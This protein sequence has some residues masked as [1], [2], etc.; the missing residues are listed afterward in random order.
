MLTSAKANSRV[1]LQ[2]EPTNA[3]DK[4]AY[5]VL[6]WDSGKLNHV[7]YV[8]R[9]FAAK[10]EAGMKAQ[11]MKFSFGKPTTLV[12]R[13]Q[14]DTTRADMFEADIIGVTNDVYAIIR[15]DEAV[16]N[17]TGIFGG[18][19][20]PVT[21]EREGI[22]SKGSGAERISRIEQVSNNQWVTKQYIRRELGL[23]DY[24]DCDTFGQIEE[25]DCF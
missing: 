5:K 10:I 21:N 17:D 6:F 23:S 25:D 13:L 8:Q 20:K 2:A 12:A 4:N 3:F 22:Y 1:F 24:S 7:G 11:D 15:Q 18:K 16:K 19:K 9:H 14:N